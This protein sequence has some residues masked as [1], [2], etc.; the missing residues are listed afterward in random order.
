MSTSKADLSNWLTFPE[1]RWA[2]ANIDK[3]PSL[4]TATILKSDDSIDFPNAARNFDA[5]ELQHDGV[6]LDLSSYLRSSATDGLIVL[7]DGQV[8]LEDYH[9][10]NTKDSKH[11]VMSI[12]KSVTGLLV[13]ILQARGKLAVDDL[14]VKYV[15]EVSGTIYKDK[16]LRQCIDMRSGAVYVD[17]QHEYRAATGW[18][19]LHGTEKHRDLKAFLSNFAP[20]TTDDRFE[21]VSANT[22]LMGWVLERASGKTFAELVQEFL[23]Q[24]MGAESDALVTLEPSGLARSA[25]GLCPTL[26]DLARVAQLIAD[27]GRNAKGE[28]V[29]PA[30]WIEDILHGGSKEAWQRGKFAPMFKGY[31]DDVAYRSYCYVDEES[32]TVMGFGVFGQA[33]LVERKHGIVLA[34]T[35][36]QEDPLN[37]DIIRMTLGAFREFKRLLVQA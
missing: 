36:S 24:P 31:F 22:D 8:L 10:G 27:D 29:V 5:F 4:P 9:N 35:R 23:W 18:H 2:F 17:G 20:E 19:P 30:D 14:V 25:G 3:I 21:Y 26:R 16:T 28:V 33:F 7:K 1:N 11:I 12:T 32:E 37:T 15:P 6:K 13:G 34:T